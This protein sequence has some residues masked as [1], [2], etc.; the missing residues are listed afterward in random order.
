MSIMKEKVSCVYL[1][2]IVIL[3]ILFYL[4]LKPCVFITSNDKILVMFPVQANDEISLRFV[5]SVQK[6][7]VLENHYVNEACDGFILKST[8]YQSF[9]V[10]LPFLLSEGDFRQ[11]GE[12]FIIDNM[13]RPFSKIDLRTGVGTK[14]T[15]LYKGTAYP[16]YQQLPVGA[17]VELKI[18]PY[19]TRFK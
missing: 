10:G 15:I 9:G 12:Y 8:K 14:L 2:C 5:H 1:M 19:Y 4:A 16:I 6:T 17:K 3:G 13:N 11:E 18:A 7:T